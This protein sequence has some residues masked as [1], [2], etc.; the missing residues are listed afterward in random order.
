MTDKIEEI[1]LQEFI[2]SVLTQIES[3]AEVGERG[4]KDA[5]EFEVTV[6]KTQ[7]LGGN[8]KVYIASGGGEVNKESIAKIKFQ[9]YPKLPKER[10]GGITHDNQENN[11]QL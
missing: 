1:E 7:K 11:W 5:I 8:V 10:L 3:G 2:Q 4:F 9:I 6:S